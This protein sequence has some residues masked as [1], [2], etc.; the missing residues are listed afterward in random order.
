M[1]AQQSAERLDARLWIGLIVL[2]LSTFMVVLD[3]SVVFIAMPSIL[4]DLG[5]TLS[6]A[7]WVIAGFLLAF[8]MLLLPA[9]KAA[10]ILGRKRLCLAGVI[11]FTLA[12]VACAFAPSMEWLI[13]ARVV[14]GVG[15]ALVEPTVLALIKRTFPP[16]QVGLAFGVQGIAAALAASIGPSLGGVLTSLAS[17]EWIFLI[18]V[19][20][21][22]VAVVGNAL[23][24]TDAPV[25]EVSRRID[26]AGFV[27]SAGMLSA[28]VYAIIEGENH[29]WSSPLILTLFAV[30]AVCLV[31]FIL[32]ERRAKEPLVPLSLFR[33]RLF[34][35]GNIL[36]GSVEFITLGVFFP[37]SLFVQIQ[38]GHSALE[39]GLI[40]L[41]LV[42]AS[43]FSS[44]LGGSLSDR[45]D[46]RFILVPG[47]ALCAVGVFLT[48]RLGHDTEWTFFIVPLAIL[49][50]GLGALYGTTV[51]VTLRNVSGGH[52][53]VAS[54]VSYTAFMLGSELGIAVVGTAMN[55]QLAANLR[56]DVAPELGIP[57]ESFDDLSLDAGA[58]FPSDPT[59]P[60]D[61]LFGTAFA[62]AVNTS[63]LICLGVAVLAVILS[64]GIGRGRT[65]AQ[66]GVQGEQFS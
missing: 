64:F 40:F 11:V 32:V 20:I 34:S 17:W 2:T 29:G 1:A 28:L 31:L 7:T 61:A 14:Q 63:L 3:G 16:R 8:I 37:L 51:N 57:P 25:G 27:L 47:F 6:Q 22:I 48:A 41:P 50:L 60:F 46:P 58:Q 21:G 10:D 18:N 66:P 52:T 13:T 39:T 35:L 19:P 5:G 24:L 12:S 38:L 53:G 15:S 23:T 36:R 33:D 44:P 59:G 56:D 9:G 45:I 65:A 30:A 42:I 54:G 62:E 43:L 55:R 49:G 26:W 4:D